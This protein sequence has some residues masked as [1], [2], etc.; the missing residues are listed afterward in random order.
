[1]TIQNCKKQILL[2]EVLDITKFFSSAQILNVWNF[3]EWAL[4]N[5][6]VFLGEIKSEKQHP[7]VVALDLTDE[8]VKVKLLCLLLKYGAK[9]T[10]AKLSE[11]H[12][13]T[14]LS[15]A[16]ELASEQSKFGGCG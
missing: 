10:T 1:M 11:R 12:G 13:T 2:L 9:I 6:K 3:L 16:I 15:I 5:A 8:P 14:F 7:L 4:A